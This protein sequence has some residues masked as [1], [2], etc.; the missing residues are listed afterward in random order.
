M[1]QRRGNCFKTVALT[2][3]R[4][5]CRPV[6]LTDFRLASLHYHMS[7]LFKIITYVY[8][9]IHAHI[10]ILG[11]PTP[12]LQTATGPQPVRNRATQQE[13]SGGRGSEASSAAPHRSPSLALLPEPSP[14]PCLWKNCLP[15]NRSLVP[16]RLGTAVCIYTCTYIYIFICTH[17]Y[18]EI[19]P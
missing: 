11:P 1:S 3:A 10:Y 12:G 7:Q 2:P 9:Y 13:V 15:Q 8:I 4:V 19:D 18:T 6:C 5:S 14:P 16:K 17:L